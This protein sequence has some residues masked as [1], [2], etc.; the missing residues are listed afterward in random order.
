MQAGIQAQAYCKVE[1][2]G[3]QRDSLRRAGWVTGP[4]KLAK[5]QTKHDNREHEPAAAAGPGPSLA[6]HLL[7]AGA[8]GQVLG[9]GVVQEET[10]QGRGVQTLEGDRVDWPESTFENFCSALPCTLAA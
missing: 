10:G 9:R 3:A 1:S 4:P 7:F 2:D 6:E 5:S 8:R